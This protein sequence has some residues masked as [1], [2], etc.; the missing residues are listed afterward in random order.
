MSASDPT[1]LLVED[2]PLVRGFLADNLTADGYDVL[3]ADTLHD[4]LRLLEFA[5]PDVAIVDV[6]LPDGSGL[7]LIARGCARPTASALRRAWI[8]RCRCSSCPGAAGR[9]TASAAS[10]AGPTTTWSSRSP[11]G[12][13]APGRRAAAALGRSRARAG[14]CASASS[15]STRRAADG[16]GRAA[17]TS[18]LSQKEF[19]LLLALAAGRRECSPRR[20]CCATSGASARMGTHAH[21]GLARLPAAPQARRGGRP[22]RGQRVGRRLP[23]RRRSRRRRRRRRDR[24]RSSSPPCH[25]WPAPGCAWRRRCLAL[26][27]QARPRA[28]RAA[29]VGAGSGCTG[30]TPV[31]PAPARGWPRSTSSC[32]AP[33]SRS[34]TCRQRPRGR[35]AAE[36]PRRRSS[37]GR[38]SRTRARGWMLLARRPWR[39]RCW[40]SPPTGRCSSAPTAC[41]WRRRARTWSRTRSSTAAAR[42]ACAHGCRPAARPGSRSP[43]A[44]AGLPAPI[45]QLLAAARGRRERRGHGLALAAGVAARYGGRLTTAPSPRGARLVLELPLAVPEAAGPRGVLRRLGRPP[46]RRGRVALLRGRGPVAPAPARRAR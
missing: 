32:A 4:A 24:A 23:A 46:S 37:S 12:A 28:A 21:A 7:D 43:T 27:A 3:V 45:S 22:V 30:S 44:A 8:R 31:V 20:S 6:G 17:P 26:V 11:T 14:S 13:A 40:S 38:C 39:R 25:G 34:R 18:A 10:T 9:S 2:D 29:A 5:P 36:S 41:G 19:A 35:R 1:V 16:A 15:R 42:C 33:R